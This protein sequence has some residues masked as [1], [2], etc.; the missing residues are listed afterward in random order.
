MSHADLDLVL[1]DPAA[2]RSQR[3]LPHSMAVMIE[4]PAIKPRPIKHRPRT[5]FRGAHGVRQRPYRSRRRLRREVYLAGC[6][7]MALVPIVS[8]CTLGW[9]NRSNRIVACSISEPF[10]GEGAV[11]HDGLT[12]KLPPAR[13]EGLAE[14]AAIDSRGVVM[15]SSE[16]AAVVAGSAAETPVIFPGYVLPDDT[17]EDLMHEGS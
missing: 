8:A 5:I 4:V 9:S 15:L 7:L 12:E 11:D 16:P 17:R 14:Q 1:T 3:V 10:R 6:T 2:N 13:E